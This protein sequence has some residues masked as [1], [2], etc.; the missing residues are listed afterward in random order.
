MCIRDSINAEYGELRGKIMSNQFKL[1]MWVLTASWACADPTLFQG[2]WSVTRQDVPVGST[3]SGTTEQGTLKVWIQAGHVVGEYV[4]TDSYSS[5]SEMLFKIANPGSDGA[6]VYRVPEVEE[7]SEDREEAPGGF[8]STDWSAGI[9]YSFHR[10][11][12]VVSSH[13]PLI[14]GG[15]FY[16]LT[17]LQTNHFVLTIYTKSGGMFSSWKVVSI[18]GERLGAPGGSSHSW[19]VRWSGVLALGMFAMSRVLQSKHL[20]CEDAAS[21]ALAPGTSIGNT[22]LL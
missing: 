20:T 6:L 17:L 2:E 19:W 22:K 16:H 18:T 5:G 8:E 11:G 13:A 7:G 9:Q 1:V 15:D 14:G 3:G 10:S 21:P 4:P 12:S